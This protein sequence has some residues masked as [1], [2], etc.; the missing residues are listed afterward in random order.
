MKRMLYHAAKDAWRRRM[1]PMS[2][3]GLAISA[4]TGLLG[5]CGGQQSTLD[6]AGEAAKDIAE[7]SRI[8]FTGA[9]ALLI[10]VVVVAATAFV[11]RGQPAANQGER[12]ILLGGVALPVVLLTALMVY[13][14]LLGHRLAAGEG[15]GAALRVHVVG[16][17]WWWRVQYLRADGSID[18]ETANELHMPI[19]RPVHLSLASDDVIHS[20]WVPP[21]GGKVDMIAGRVNHLR[22]TADRPGIL[23][24]QCAEFCGLQ[25]AWM[26]LYVIAEPADAFSLWRAQQARPASEPGDS[27]LRE[28]RH[29]FEEA[30]C[31][32]CHTVRGTAAAGVDGPDLTHVG[33]RHSLAAG[34]LPNTGGTLAAWI[35]DSQHLKPG[36]LMPSFQFYGPDLPKLAD[37]LASLQ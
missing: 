16:K 15:N 17:Q 13:V 4:G 36:N 2:L 29:V 20:F 8:L 33:S 9:T 12:I 28:G 35:A 34:R 22:L 11:R 32:A 27:R 1:R 31:G 24:G 30:G 26:A 7:L 37:W 10:L 18:F 19:G 5:G 23:R 14:A 3:R 21:L 25:H 6:P